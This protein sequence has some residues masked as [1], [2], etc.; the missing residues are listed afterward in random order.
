MLFCTLLLSTGAVAAAEVGLNP[1]DGAILPPDA[2]KRLLNQ[3]SRGTPQHVIG[4]WSPAGW[5]VRELESRLAAALAIEAQRRRFRYAQPTA[6]RR[7]YVG[8]LIGGRRIIYVN[9]FPRDVGD[10]AK[11]G[12]PATRHFDWRREP[13]IVCDGGPAFFGVEYDSQK[14]TFVHF[15]FNGPP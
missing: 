8:L 3:C 9:A 6:F 4:I 2:G 7:Q 5:Q 10:P 15:E 14:R 1:I 12:T 13:L 11:D